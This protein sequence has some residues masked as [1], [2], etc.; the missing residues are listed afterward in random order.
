V[1]LGGG[2]LCWSAAAVALGVQGLNE[3]AARWLVVSGVGG[4]VGVGVWLG[5]AC[6][7]DVLDEGLS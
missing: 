3:S 6:G 4:V 5:C 1:W 7:R 2:G